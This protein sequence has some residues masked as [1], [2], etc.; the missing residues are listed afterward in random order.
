MDFIT[1]L[2]ASP[3]PSHSLSSKV[4]G[5]NV[6][7]TSHSKILHSHKNSS[8]TITL[9]NQRVR[10]TLDG[11]ITHMQDE[12]EKMSGPERTEFIFKT[13]TEFAASPTFQASYLRCIDKT[14]ETVAS[15]MQEALNKPPYAMTAEG[16]Q[17]PMTKAEAMMQEAETSAQRAEQAADIAEQAQ[18]T[19]A[20]AGEKIT[21]VAEVPQAASAK[22]SL[23][24]DR[25]QWTQA[26]IQAD[27]AKQAQGKAI[28]QREQ[29]RR[30][31]ETKIW[32]H[33]KL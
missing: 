24:L 17:V 28:D 12:W 8:R 29:L 31:I 19:P 3:A 4:L 21:P 1:P 6:I 7:L 13:I 16:I 30:L 27:T 32:R 15:H 23:P 2:K 14:F 10:E 22:D 5:S 20:A 18:K 11:V 25:R 26:Q 9:S 33:R